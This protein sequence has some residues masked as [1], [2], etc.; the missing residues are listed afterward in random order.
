MKSGLHHKLPWQGEQN[1]HKDSK[2]TLGIT[3]T[4]NNQLHT[5]IKQAQR[6]GQPWEH[7]MRY[8]NKRAQESLSGIPTSHSPT[9]LFPIAIL[10][11]LQ[12]HKE[13]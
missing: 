3:T 2:Q 7:S 13:Q 1:E 6:Y 4:R 8:T 12:D 10:L 11:L 5:Q 9:T